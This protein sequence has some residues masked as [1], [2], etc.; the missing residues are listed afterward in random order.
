MTGRAV[1]DEFKGKMIKTLGFILSEM[2]SHWR[3][4]GRDV[5]DPVLCY[6]DPPSVNA[7]CLGMLLAES[8][9]CL[10]DC[11]SFRDLLAFS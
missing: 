5:V 2:G 9:Q 3:E 1:R 7:C 4:M 10:R 6:L 11:L 8:Q